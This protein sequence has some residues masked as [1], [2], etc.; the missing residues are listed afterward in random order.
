MRARSSPPVV[1]TFRTF[2]P[3]SVRYLVTYQ[4]IRTE[5]Q[6]RD[7]VHQFYF[8]HAP[9]ELLDP[10]FDLYPADPAAGSPFFTGDAN[11]LAPMYKRMSAFQGDFMFEA[12]RRSLLTLRSSKQPAWAYRA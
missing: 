2:Y 11:Q 12:Q 10:L 7:Y 9:K 6:F 3:T 8:P 1:G 4:I 5:Q